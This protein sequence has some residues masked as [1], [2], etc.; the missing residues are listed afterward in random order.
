MARDGATPSLLRVSSPDMKNRAEIIA[1]AISQVAS[2]LAEGQ[3]KAT[4]SIK[5][6]ATEL[7]AST[8]L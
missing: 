2:I 6:I 1:I 5:N 3:K 7:K 4:C 8:K